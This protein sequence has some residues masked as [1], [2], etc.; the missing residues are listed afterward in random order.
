[1][2]NRN[3]LTQWPFFGLALALFGSLL[4]TPDTLLI[5]LSGFSGWATICWRG[6]EMGT[7]LL[8]LWLLLFRRSASKDVRQIF[9]R[10][11]LA[12]TC[13]QTSAGIFFSLAVAETSVAIV[14]FC[15][16]ICPV[17]AA[18]FSKLLLNERTGLATWLTMLITFVGIGIAV[19]DGHSALLVGEHGKGIVWLGA[20]YAICAAACLGLSFVCIRMN[21]KLNILLMS[22][23]QASISGVIGLGVIMTVAGGLP[24]LASGHIGYIS[25]DSLFILPASFI[26]LSWATRYT[27][28]ANVSLLMLL[29]TILGPL[30]VWMVIGEAASAQMVV[31]GAIVVVALGVYI[32]FTAHTAR[33]ARA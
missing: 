3:R 1:M 8:L 12:A 6:L 19:M 24:A 30:W 9:T 7:L 4:I 27:Q 29:E 28:A 31:G 14:L 26:C 11:G 32:S 23:L 5:R 2:H 21:T 18:L 17:F 15:L 25:F 33:T 20:L 22:G 13:A 16:A 10:S